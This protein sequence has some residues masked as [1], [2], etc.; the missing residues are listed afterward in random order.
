MYRAP[1]WSI[2][3][4]SVVLTTGV[5]RA[6][7]FFQFDS[8]N[9]I[10]NTPGGSVTVNVFLA[11]NNTG[12]ND[13]A[14]LNAF[15]LLG[16]GV[17]LNPIQGVFPQIT[18][19]PS[20]VTAVNGNPQFDSGASVD[21]TGAPGSVGFTELVVTNPTV[22]PGAPNPPT[23][24]FL[25]SFTFTDQLGV[26]SQTTIDAVMF[27]PTATSASNSVFLLGNLGV[28]GSTD[29]NNSDNGGAGPPGGGDDVIISATATITVDLT[30]VPEPSSL[31]LCG[32]AAAGAFGYWR[33]RKH[34]SP[35]P[36]PAA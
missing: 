11:A 4:L 9:Y 36:T 25:G 10:I 8:N 7:Y 33:R 22:F 17:R 15:G 6:D 27:D 26:N 31:A 21:N 23:S 14:E 28:L 29:G 24:I 3:A 12:T 34:A 20:I 19:P 16:A 13:L 35:A 18:P 2:L 5:S 1:L 30:N 32:M